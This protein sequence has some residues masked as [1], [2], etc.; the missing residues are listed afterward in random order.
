MP[1]MLFPKCLRGRDDCEPFDAIDA[2]PEGVTEEQIMMV[3]YEPVSFVCVGCIS[4]EKRKLPQDAYRVC[5]KNPVVDEM[6]NYD[7]QD[8]T[9]MSAC[10]GRALAV[11]STRRVNGGMIDVPTEQGRA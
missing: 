7:E 6:G 2:P 11:I 1:I 10:V 4:E 8:L 5:W 9:H 3:D